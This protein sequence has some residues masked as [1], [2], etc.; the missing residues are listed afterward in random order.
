[1]ER[2]TDK[3]HLEFDLD[4]ATQTYAKSDNDL[5]G[6]IITSPFDLYSVERLRD[7]HNLR[8]GTR[9]PTDIFVFGQGTP[10][11]RG[12][13]KIS[14]LPYWPKAR[15]WPNDQ[16]GNFMQFLAQ[17]SFVDS[18]DIV[19]DLP[20]DILVIFV[21]QDNEDWLWETERVRLEWVKACDNDLIEELP[22]GIKP[23]SHSEWY[24]VIHRSEDYPDSLAKARTLD[25][26]QA[27]KLV[28]TSGT[29]IGGSLPESLQPAQFGINP[30]TGKPIKLPKKKSGIE[31][32][33]I[34]QIASI[35]AHPDVP[36]PWT[37]QKKSLGTKFD[38]SGIYGDSNQFVLGDMGSIY[39]LRNTEGNCSAKFK[40]S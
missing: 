5:S 23:F 35:Q 19:G 33:I 10:K 3:T 16:D 7:L 1:M 38:K 14:G 37:N 24:G 15:A 39:I 20:G 2:K 28:L 21:P 34:C 26:D 32:Q 25:V 13:T 29:K 30:T 17:V 27:A 4:F 31:Q 22:T 8:K 9:S 40:S 18:K 12:V 36:Y 6:E 11:N